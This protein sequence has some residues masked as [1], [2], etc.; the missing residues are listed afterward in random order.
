MDE[1]VKMFAKN[2]GNPDVET[3][4]KPQTCLLPPMTMRE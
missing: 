3:R 2:D 1:V 4:L